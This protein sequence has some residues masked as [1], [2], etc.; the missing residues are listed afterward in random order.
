MKITKRQLRKLIREQVESVLPAH[1]RSAEADRWTDLKDGVEQLQR[2]LTKYFEPEGYGAGTYDPMG[3][4]SPDDDDSWDRMASARKA[5][6]SDPEF[7]QAE[8][9][10]VGLNLRA[11]NWQGVISKITIPEGGWGGWSSQALLKVTDPATGKTVTNLMVEDDY[12]V[13]DE[14]L[15][16]T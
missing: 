12:F 10:L 14:I 4:N 3:T 15:E 9:W 2:L 8:D 5:L 6:L 11:Y 16:V 1:A 13:A 7:A